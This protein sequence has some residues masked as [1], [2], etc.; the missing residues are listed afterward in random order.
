SGHVK[1]KNSSSA[2][3]PTAGRCNHGTQ[4]QR[5]ARRPPS[6]TNTM[7]VRC[8]ST[9][10]SAT[11]RA[12]TRPPL[13]HDLHRE[14]APVALPTR[15]QRTLHAVADSPG[16]PE[17]GERIV[18]IVCLKR[19]ARQQGGESRALARPLGV[20]ERHSLSLARSGL[21]SVPEAS[22]GPDAEA[23]LGMAF[24]DPPLERGG[25]G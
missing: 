8:T 16:G 1:P 10:R 19:P 6:A 2:P 24:A 11:A 7:K 13:H 9:T 15:R 17:R 4:R 5:N 18:Q 22:A 12:I 25:P 20:D 3:Q 21:L 23:H 14:P